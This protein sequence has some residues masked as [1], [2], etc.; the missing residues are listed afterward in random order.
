MIRCLQCGH[1]NRPARFSGSG[2]VRCEVC[3]ARLQDVE[4]PTSPTP[5]PWINGKWVLI[6]FLSGGV[7]FSLAGAARYQAFCRVEA[8]L[9]RQDQEERNGGASASLAQAEAERPSQRTPPAVQT[10][11]LPPK[12]TE[13]LSPGSSVR[14]WE[15]EWQ[16]RLSQDAA[17]A[18]S[19][20]EKR[21]LQMRSL[22]K[23][24][25]SPDAQTL[26]DIARLAAPAGSRVEVSPEG[27]L[28]VIRVAFPM[29]SMSA[30]EQGVATKHHSIESLREEVRAIS[31]QLARDILSACGARGVR[32]LTVSCNRALRQTLIPEAATP[33]ERA[34][35]LARSKVA[36]RRIY[37]I[38]VEVDP[39]LGG[40][41]WRSV[42]THRIQE[43]M[44]VEQDDLRLIA[45]EP[46]SAFET[47]RQPDP[48]EMLEF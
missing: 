16:L 32:R 27:D 33:E 2:P 23:S 19:P 1:D 42:G 48:G 28:Q 38:A 6:T 15:Q 24:D 13:G 43:L 26:R 11:S 25:V 3:S 12:A 20:L 35:L 10:A 46:G 39:S 31:A 36:M 41:D 7:L 8:E 40:M 22:G 4:D 30:R 45:I 47:F 44:K 34:E 14:R 29:S 9:A 21:L 37:R 18:V 5:P 17:F